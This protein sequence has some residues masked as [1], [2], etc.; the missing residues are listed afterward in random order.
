MTPY[1]PA[2][3]DIASSRSSTDA[4]KKTRRVERLSLL[5]MARISSPV[6]PGI[7]MSMMA[8]SGAKLRIA[9]MQPVPLL[10]DATTLKPLAAPSM[11]VKPC[12][13]TG[14]WSAITTLVQRMGGPQ[15]LP[16]PHLNNP[17]RRFFL[18]T[19]AESQSF[20]MTGGLQRSAKDSSWQFPT[21]RGRS[22][23][24]L[25]TPPITEDIWGYRGL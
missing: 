25:T 20:S 24:D 23:D 22:C 2:S 18:S 5:A 13:T 3:A 7:E 11:F 16:H 15:P 17:A 12:R 14:W 10:Q 4:V 8:M 19:S 6:R 9:W 1:A 21:H